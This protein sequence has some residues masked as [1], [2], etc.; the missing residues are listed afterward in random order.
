M[1]LLSIDKGEV[2]H[3]FDLE[4]YTVVSASSLRPFPHFFY[5]TS[6]YLDLGKKMYVDLSQKEFKPEVS[7]FILNKYE[8]LLYQ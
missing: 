2:L 4:G 6:S 3:E 1:V 5:E 7:K 8:F